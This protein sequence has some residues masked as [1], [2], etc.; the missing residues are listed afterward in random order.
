MIG[1]TAKPKGALA[2]TRNNIGYGGI[3]NKDVLSYQEMCKNKKSLMAFCA[4]DICLR[5][6]KGTSPVY[7]VRKLSGKCF[8]KEVDKDTVECP[9]CGHGLFWSRS[10]VK[11]GSLYDV[12]MIDAADRFR[13]KWV[14]RNTY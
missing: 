14:N 12:Y 8:A 1:I 4:S 7:S 5:R 13:N 11:L 3:L 9:D 10:W 6:T 2:H